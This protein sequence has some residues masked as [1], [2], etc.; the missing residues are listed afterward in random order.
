MSQISK[1]AANEF[2]SHFKKGF[3]DVERKE[4]IDYAMALVEKYSEASSELAC[5]MYERIAELSSVNIRPAEPA[6]PA[7]YGEVAKGINGTFKQSPEGRL[8]SDVVDRLVKRA[9]ADTML[10]NAER[11]G[12]QFAWVPSGDTC[13]FC[14][15][16]ASRGWQNISKKAWKNGHAEHIHAHC[17]CQY[18]VRFDNKTE[19]EGY[20]PDKY[21][22]MYEN[23]EGGNWKEKLNAMRR[24]ERIEF[25]NSKNTPDRK[26]WTDVT[27]LYYA[28]ASP[29]KGQYIKENRFTDKNGEEKVGNLIY[30]VFGGDLLLLSENN[31]D[32]DTNPDYE[33]KKKL[34]DLKTPKTLNGVDKR[35]RHGLHQIFKN[36]GG[37]IIDIRRLQIDQNE[38][39]EKIRKRVRSSSKQSVDIMII[40]DDQIIKV[41]RYNK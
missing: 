8:C 6:S 26:N 3:Q 4:V 9:G 25:I 16:L 31:P 12:A 35:V 20:D 19:V 28:Q 30:K 22:E 18:C 41:M 2:N 23:A 21:L 17:D 7:D 13:S 24:S 37:L 36:P 34:W 38:I 15:M 5:Q 39:E 40:N 1:Q 33:W 27:E 11:D 14:I 10:K 32:G 29:G